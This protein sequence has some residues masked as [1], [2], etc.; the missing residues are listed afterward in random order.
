MA[1]GNHELEIFAMLLAPWAEACHLCILQ[2]PRRH[3]RLHEGSANCLP[4]G[5]CS[6]ENGWKFSACWPKCRSFYV[7]YNLWYIYMLNM[8]SVW[9][10]SLEKRKKELAHTHLKCHL[11]LCSG[12]CL[13][14]LWA[15]PM[16]H[17]S[18]TSNLLN[19]WSLVSN[20]SDQYLNFSR[21]TLNNKLMIIW[22][23]FSGLFLRIQT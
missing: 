2:S 15:M 23:K 14:Q 11:C 6:V 18:Y 7:L 17:A 12:V 22:L 9:Y 10:L 8:C 19:F 4:L 1:T 21:A 16:L 3:P 20:P 13:Y 5:T